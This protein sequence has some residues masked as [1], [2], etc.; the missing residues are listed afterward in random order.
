MRNGSENRSDGVCEKKKEKS[1]VIFSQ[2]IWDGSEGVLHTENLKVSF[3]TWK[4]VWEDSLITET[5]NDSPSQSFL[6]FLILRDPLYPLTSFSCFLCCC[7]LSGVHLLIPYFIAGW[8]S[9]WH[10]KLPASSSCSL[11]AEK[12]NLTELSFFSFQS[13]SPLFVLLCL[14]SCIFLSSMTNRHSQTTDTDVEEDTEVCHTLSLLLSHCVGD[15][16]HR[17]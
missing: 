13:L 6:A 8:H 17:K 16:L 9:V 11:L 14:S 12:N 3:A 10:W 5:A 7:L 4:S 1:L 2:I 15:I